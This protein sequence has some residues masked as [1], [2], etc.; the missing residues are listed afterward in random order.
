MNV[1]AWKR[2]TRR[3]RSAS[4]GR[5]ASLAVGFGVLCILA[6][7]VPT[8]N[9]EDPPVRRDTPLPLLEDAGPDVA[10]Q[11]SLPQFR[12]EPEVGDSLVLWLWV[13]DPMP[14]HW[15]Q[16]LFVV[17]G[18][19]EHCYVI[20]HED[21]WNVTM[22]QHDVDAVIERWENSSIGPYPDM[23]IYDI[24]SQVFGDPPD[25]LDNDP[26]IY[27]AWFDNGIFGDGFFFY[28]DQYPEGTFPGNHSNEREIL[29][30]N[31]T[32]QGGPSG[33]Y[34]LSVMAHEFE[35][36]IHWLYDEDEWS[37]VDEGMAELAMWFYGR[38]DVISVF[39]SNPD[40]D[41]TSWDQNWADYIQTYLW[42]LYFYERYGGEPAVL[43]LVH[44]AGNSIAGYDAVLDD[45]GY[46]EDFEDVFADWV[47]ANYLDD[48]SLADGRYGYVGEELPSFNVMRTFD[49]SDYPVIDFYRT[50]NHWA[51]DYYRFR[52]VDDFESFR[53]EF[54]G[55]DN[56]RFAVWA[57]ALHAD[58]TTDVIRMP[59]EE[60]S[61]TGFVD[62][63]GLSDP[64]DEVV[65][66]IA[67]ISSSGSTGYYLSA[68]ASPAAIAG[69]PDGAPLRLAVRATPNPFRGAVTLQL[70]GPAESA[71]GIVDLFDAQGRRVR[72]L[73][74]A[75]SQAGTVVWD[76]RAASGQPVAPG[77]YYVRGRRAGLVDE[78]KLLRLP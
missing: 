47:V 23:G 59:I 49:G 26:R 57:L 69:E 7:L 1:F 11:G 37:W 5:V 19:D 20:V 40:N 22:N 38:P 70:R 54:D 28:F 14:P 4:G 68:M 66:A 34:M 2:A 58:G 16:R 48:P 42:S 30:L 76:G 72:S 12:T 18:K 33:D 65:M 6:A 15:E 13:H 36:M 56:N 29:Y 63:P 35:H 27:L 64:D 8:A 67:S 77:L 74:V 75:P 53:L 39:N 60:A 44:E 10:W 50:V 51:A 17:R 25:E 73:T 21:E 45:Y 31:T 32:S 3:P 61:Q 55:P 43:D 9:A 62:V 71:S 46:S 78:Q 24:N 41:L 52:D